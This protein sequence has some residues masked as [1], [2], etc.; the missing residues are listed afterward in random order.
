M[1]VDAEEVLVHHSFLSLTLNI[2]CVQIHY[3]CCIDNPERRIHFKTFTKMYTILNEPGKII[4]SRA[5]CKVGSFLQLMLKTW[6]VH[7]YGL[8][9]KTRLDATF[10]YQRYFIKCT[11][12]FRSVIEL[13]TKFRWKL[14][15]I[16]FSLR[17]IWHTRCRQ[18]YFDYQQEAIDDSIELLFHLNSDLSDDP[19]TWTFR[20][21]RIT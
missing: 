17:L 20:A 10:L 15:S 3:T 9:P 8:F 16:C 18:F 7:S 1:A 19:P 13:L 4:L 14:K 6:T 12:E 11:L 21:V 2:P 5:S